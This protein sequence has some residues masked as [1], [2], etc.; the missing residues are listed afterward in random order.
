[1]SQGH[2]F[3]IHTNKRSHVLVAPPLVSAGDC[4][5][6]GSRFMTDVYLAQSTDGGQ[7]WR[8]ADVRVTTVSPDSRRQL[9]PIAGCRT[10][11]AMEEVFTAS[12]RQ[13]RQ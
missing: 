11:L 9:D 2:V 5:T 1:M 8:G 12:V 3:A 13:R 10:E 4:D 7:S 6:T